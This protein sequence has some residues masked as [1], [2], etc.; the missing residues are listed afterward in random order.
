MSTTIASP[1]GAPREAWARLTEFQRQVY[2]A[3]SAIPRGQTRSYRWV[4]RRIGRPDA[5]RAVGNALT[6]NA[7]APRVPCHRVVRADGSLGGFAG[8]PKRK[9]ALLKREGAVP[10]P[11]LG[12]KSP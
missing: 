6:R 2:R 4:A 1:P 3:V 11:D 7:F 12:R 9:L 8:G 5:A 10:L